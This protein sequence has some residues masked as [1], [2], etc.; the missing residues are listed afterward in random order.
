MKWSLLHDTLALKGEWGVFLAVVVVFLAV[1][2]VFV[3]S[4]VVTV[5]VVGMVVA[6]GAVLVR[7]SSEVQIIYE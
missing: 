7:A 5:F 4:D 6:T 1:V 2:V 3:E